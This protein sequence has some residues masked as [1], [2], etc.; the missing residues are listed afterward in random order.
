MLKFIRTE[1]EAFNLSRIVKIYVSNNWLHIGLSDGTEPRIV[2]GTTEALN[3]LLDAIM[4]F[5]GNDATVFDCTD[6]MKKNS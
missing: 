4:D 3:A 1:K 2:Y 5:A 6:F